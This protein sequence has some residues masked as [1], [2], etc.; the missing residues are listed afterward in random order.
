[1]EFDAIPENVL[2]K[3]LA[4]AATK[5]CSG[6]QCPAWPLNSGGALNAIK[7]SIPSAIAKPLRTV[8]EVALIR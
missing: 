4:T 3:Q 1:L 5:K 6:V 8:V 7:G 2:R